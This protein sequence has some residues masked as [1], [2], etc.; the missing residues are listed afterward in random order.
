MISLRYK[1]SQGD[2]TLFIKH[3]VT[4]K[5]TWLLVY[6]VIWLQEDDTEKLA[7]K[8]TLANQFEMKNMGKLK[9]FFG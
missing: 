1:Q 9:Y 8:K 4:Y 6:A 2:H 7:L 3:S 5:P